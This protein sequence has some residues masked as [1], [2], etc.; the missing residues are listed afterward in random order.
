MLLCNSIVSQRPCLTCIIGPVVVPL[1]ANQSLSNWSC[2]ANSLVVIVGFRPVD[3]V[4]VVFFAQVAF[5]CGD[6]AHHRRLFTV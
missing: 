1:V 6:V 3:A 5:A 2:M 4:S